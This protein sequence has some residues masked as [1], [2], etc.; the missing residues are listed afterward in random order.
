MKQLTTTLTF[1]VCCCL[2]SASLADND[3]NKIRKDIKVMNK[4]IT[5]AL[6]SDDE[7]GKC[8]ASVRGSYLAGQGAMFVISPRRS[9]FGDV[10]ITDGDWGVQHMELEDLAALEGLPEMIDDIVSGVGIAI[11]DIDID[12]ADHGDHEDHEIF[13]T[14]YGR[15]S[16]SSRQARNELR[17]LQREMRQLRDEQRQQEIELI[18]AEDELKKDLE[19]SIRKLESE[20]TTLEAKREALSGELDKQRERRSQER[21]K[22]RKIAAEARQKQNTLLEH[23]VLS[24]MCDYGASLKNLPQKERVTLLFER[25][26]KRWS[27][28][29]TRMYVMDKKDLL[30]CQSN[31]LDTDGLIKK[32]I[33]YNF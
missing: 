33:A 9:H 21:E 4:I 27:E 14:R 22:A 17:S 16:D 1:L 31:T 10:S 6:E 15:Q 2:T 30:A 3:F 11:R 23:L 28:N 19:N 8:R 20:M 5:T 12:D 26:G 29:K 13:T 32:S 25:E 7:C 24:T 18:R